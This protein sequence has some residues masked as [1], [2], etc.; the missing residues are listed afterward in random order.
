MSVPTRSDSSPPSDLKPQYFVA[1]L[2]CAL[3]YLYRYA[4][5]SAPGVM[6]DELTAAWGGNHI[7]SMISAYYAAYAVSALAAASCW[8]A[9]APHA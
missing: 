4:A 3:F 6:Q 5:R 7:G 9:T 1:W 2:L 8:T